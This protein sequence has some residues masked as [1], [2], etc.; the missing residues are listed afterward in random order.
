MP[1]VL[2]KIVSKTD[3][4]SP[5]STEQT[6][7]FCFRSSGKI[8]FDELLTHIDGWGKFQIKLLILFIQFTFFLAYVGYSPILYLHVPDHHCTIPQEYLDKFNVTNPNDLL[9]I[10]IPYDDNLQ[11]RSQCYMYDMSDIDDIFE[12]N[13]TLPLH[14]CTHG[15]T[16]DFTD[17]FPSVS[18]QVSLFIFK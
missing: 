6:I 7:V 11:K 13:K 16:Y 10:L 5:K 1:K 15:W 3:P 12:L 18:T 8:E 17:H 4:K 2:T 14:K 9:D